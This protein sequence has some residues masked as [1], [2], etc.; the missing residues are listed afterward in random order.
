MLTQVILSGDVVVEKIE[1]IEPE[2]D[3]DEEEEES[4]EDE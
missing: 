3:D 1:Q 4:E 2:D